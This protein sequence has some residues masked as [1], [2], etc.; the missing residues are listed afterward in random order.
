M[1]TQ[2]ETQGAWGPYKYMLNNKIPITGPILIVLF[3]FLVY[4]GRDV[5]FEPLTGQRE[6]P[7]GPQS[8]M[9][10][11][12]FSGSFD[13]V[14]AT[15]VQPERLEEVTP[16]EVAAATADTPAYE[17]PLMML[18]EPVRGKIGRN[19]SFYIEMRESDVSPVEIDRIV[20]ATKKT[21]NLKRVRPGQRFELYPGFTGGID[22]LT[23]HINREQR[24]KIRRNAQNRFDAEIEEIPATVTYHVTHGTI[25]SS[26]FATLREQGAK[27]ELA[28]ALDEIFG[29]TIDF[30]TDTRR[31]DQFTILYA[32]K[33]FEDGSTAL[34]EVLSATVVNRGTEHH[35]YRFKPNGGQTGY[36]DLEG[37]SLQKSLRRA[38][39]K[40]TRVTSN[41]TGRRFHPVYKTYRPH[42]GVDYGAPRGTRV[43]STGDGVVL[44]AGRRKGNGNYVKI[45]HNNTYTSYY[46]HLNGFARG[47]K[48]GRR[49]KQGQLIGYVGSTGA[50]TASHVC[51]RIK[52]NGSWVNPRRL[53][54]PSK[55]PVPTATMAV[56]ESTRD[57]CVATI[58]RSIVNGLQNNTTVVERPSIAS[59]QLSSVF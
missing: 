54:L 31:G 20:R 16:V 56:Y 47:I 33:T 2:I 1:A 7:P 25:H 4:A 42:Y 41:F 23:L 12:G 27:T 13:G 10:A 57:A 34:G 32:R 24:L 30:I 45:K 14:E 36:Y 39:I 43:Y 48:S 28:S 51:Y 37:K 29:W 26:I 6:A 11:T 50:A 52:R 15:L 59:D 22:S 46:L 5:L 19:S 21:Y 3:A 40:F 9:E 53:K 49:V 17:R 18:P 35:A 58:A 44:T 55:A 8:V 38:P